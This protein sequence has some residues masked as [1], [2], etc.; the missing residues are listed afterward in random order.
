MY[1]DINTRQL[2]ILQIN[3]TTPLYEDKDDR[4]YP[5]ANW[6]QDGIIEMIQKYHYSM[7]FNN[8]LKGWIKQ[9]HNVT[10]ANKSQCLVQMEYSRARKSGQDVK[11]VDQVDS[12][13][14]VDPN[15]CRK[16]IYTPNCDKEKFAIAEVVQL[17]QLCEEHNGR[18]YNKGDNWSSLKNV[19]T[20][21]KE[22]K[23]AEKEKCFV[24]ETQDE[25]E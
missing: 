11:F 20:E 25:S 8:S 10:M 9:L 2:Y 3:R 6:A 1:D 14:L 7:N 19:T 21:L 18:M 23:D 17:N 22:E 24:Q 15:R 16:K 13:P 5:M 12:T 4:K